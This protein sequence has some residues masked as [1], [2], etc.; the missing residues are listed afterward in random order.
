[1]PI[2]VSEFSFSSNSRET[3]VDSGVVE[4]DE[5]GVFY[6]PLIAKIISKGETRQQA[7]D[8]LFSA[9]D[10]TQVLRVLQ[11]QNIIPLFRFVDYQPI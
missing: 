11:K 2:D 1:M 9:L 7:I 6:D 5:I 4:K 10:K 3:R 8:D